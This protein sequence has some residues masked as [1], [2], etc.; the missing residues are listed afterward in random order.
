MKDELI[1]RLERPEWQFQYDREK[2]RHYGSRIR[3]L[4]K[5]ITV[6]LPGIVA[7]WE[8]KQEKAVEEI[9]YY[10]EEALLAMHRE[11]TQAERIFTCYPLY[12]LSYGARGRKSVCYNRAHSRNKDL[13]CS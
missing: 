2:K 10:V 12:F 5:G 3:K 11:G 13:L 7:K 1:R 4:K 6:S 8:Q 9:V